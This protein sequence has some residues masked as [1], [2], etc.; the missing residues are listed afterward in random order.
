M[1]LAARPAGSSSRRRDAWLA[2]AGLALAALQT[3]GLVALLWGEKRAVPWA[4]VA[5]FAVANASWAPF[6]PLV[7]RWTEADFAAGLTLRRQLPRHLARALLVT[8]AL[9]LGHFAL[10]NAV[11]R[12]GGGPAYRFREVVDVEVSGGL[13]GDLIVYAALV[14]G[15]AAATA[16]SQLRQR[17]IEASRLEAALAR[18]ELRLL[19]AQLD[20][21]FLFNALHAITGQI[22]ADPAAAEAMTCRL[23]DFLRRSLA[24]DGVEEVTLAREVEHLQSYLEIQ[25]LRFP[26]RFAVDLEI[27]PEARSCAVP[28]LL[29]QPLLE[30]VATHAVA[31]RRRPVR[32][33]VRARREGGR[34][35][36]EIEDDGPGLGPAPPVAGIGLTNTRERLARLYGEGHAFALANRA[37]GGARVV[38]DLPWREHGPPSAVGLPP[39]AAAPPPPLPVARR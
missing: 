6:C 35:R 16:A 15:T 8:T 1:V 14:G 19:R 12:L 26:G 18:T 37:E 27:A 11:H 3:L 2:A 28:S 9:S 38:V 34:L 21:H 5:W 17:A 36:I 23:S 30:N 29:L 13:I 25:L 39:A 22:H 4:N 33:V 24:A 20:P 32:A 7:V 10:R 31:A